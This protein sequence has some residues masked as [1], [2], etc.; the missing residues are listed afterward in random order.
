[1]DCKQFLDNLDSGL[2]ELGSP[3]M[4]AHLSECSACQRAANL[5]TESLAILRGLPEPPV[6]SDLGERIFDFISKDGTQPRRI[7]RLGWALALAATLMLGVGIGI[8]LR[9][10]AIAPGNNY[11]VRNGT[12]V[13]PADTVTQVRIALDAARP[14]Q[15]VAFTINVPAGMHLQGHPGERQVAWNGALAKG[16]NVLNLA[17]VADRGTA[18][19]LEA[20]LQ[21][22]NHSSA[23]K[24]KV[25]ATDQSSFRNSLHRLL[26]RINLV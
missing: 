5:K 12:I 3:Q 14:L 2:V 21:Y 15:H 17:L 9:W 6:P 16:R 22:T 26:A 8:T 18:G 23:Y 24:V 10:A 25:V 4:Q 1:M 7:P 19:T 11:Q 13:V 20:D